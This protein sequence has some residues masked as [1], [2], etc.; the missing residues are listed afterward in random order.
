MHPTE[1]AKLKFD[2]LSLV[3]DMPVAC[4]WSPE[5]LLEVAEKLYRYC[6]E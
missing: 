6:S 2:I 3:N 5:K 4:D 1:K